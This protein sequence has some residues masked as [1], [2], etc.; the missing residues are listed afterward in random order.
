M[1]ELSREVREYLERRLDRAA[2]GAEERPA[3]RKWV[4][5]Y[6]DFCGKY[7]HPPRAAKSIEPFLAKL[8]SKRQT[9]AQLE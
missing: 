4:R 6:L 8:A 7:R 5:Y 1:Q 9:G 2:I 3:Y